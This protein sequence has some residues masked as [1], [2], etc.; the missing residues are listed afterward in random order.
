MKE[1]TKTIL[2]VV[3][4]VLG[5]FGV[6]FGFYLFFGFLGWLF[7]DPWDLIDDY[8]PPQ[9]TQEEKCRIQVRN[10]FDDLV[11]TW[12]VNT[13]NQDAISKSMIEIYDRCVKE[14]N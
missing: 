4:I 5:F 6:I 14:I 1:I 7:S 10:M 2:A 3:A 9:V 12:G 11:D 13:N 8:Q